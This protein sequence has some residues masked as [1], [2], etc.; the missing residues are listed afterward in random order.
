MESYE[1]AAVRVTYLPLSAPLHDSAEQVGIA[2][3]N[4]MLLVFSAIAC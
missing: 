2:L 1:D 4:I 3:C